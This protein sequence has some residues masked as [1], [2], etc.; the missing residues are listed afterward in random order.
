MTPRKSRRVWALALA[1]A[2][3][4]WAG[5]DANAAAIPYGTSGFIDT[6]IGGDFTA[7]TYD[8]TNGTVTGM[9]SLN[10]G[11]FVVTPAAQSGPTVDYTGDT[12][13]IFVYSG[14]GQSTELSGVLGGM[15]GASAT[16]PLTATITSVTPF[17]GPLPFTLNVA[18]GIAMPIN[19]TPGS[20]S[21]STTIFSAAAA[22]IPEPASLAVFAAALSGLALWRRRSAR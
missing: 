15:I 3:T 14:P 7:V 21:E 4:A 13:H 8:G 9:G 22:P 5:R 6:P 16:T 10:L 11:Q 1:L 2:V 17:E 12:F 18:T 20:T 19:T